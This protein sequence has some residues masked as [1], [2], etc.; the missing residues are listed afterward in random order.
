[1]AGNWPVKDDLTSME[2]P[3]FTLSKN[4]S[5]E[6]RSYRRGNNSLKVIPS[7]IGAPTIFDKDLL[8]FIIS[9]IARAINEGKPA[10][11]R[12]Q[13]DVYPFLVAT[14]R[15]TGGA[16]YERVID[17]L[18]R[19]RGSTIETNVKTTEEECIHGFGFIEGYRVVQR[20]RNDKG[21][22]QLEVTVSE[23][24]YRA[25]LDFDVLTISPDYFSLAA[26]ERRV[27]EL[28]RKHCGDQPWWTVSLP[29]LQ[30]KTG[31]TNSARRF[32]FDVK[33]L[34]EANSLPEYRLGLDDSVKPSQLVVLTRDNNRLM[35][36]ATKANKVD[37]VAQFLRPTS[38]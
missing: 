23:W 7:N 26:L 25:A 12:V 9:Q 31:S 27:Y 19:L 5:M 2:F 29:L 38:P 3:L 4:P 21:A 20:T 17:M 33:N 14:R 35:A 11:R 6:L 30:D 16:A 34:V 24:L 36:H 18:R 22:L 10:S 28:A 37:W 8:I 1:V 15:S 32:H 13:F